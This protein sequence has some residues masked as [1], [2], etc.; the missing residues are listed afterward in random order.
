MDLLLRGK[1]VL[2]TGGSRGIGLAIA[3]VF[4]EEGAR[5]VICS[6]SPRHL[7]AAAKQIGEIIAVPCDVT[8]PREVRALLK[9][10][11]PLDVLVNNA[12]GMEHYGG[13]EGTTAGTW[14]RTMEANLISAVE[15]IR[16]ARAGLAERRGCVVNIAS[17]AARQPLRL[18]PDY[19]AAKAAL[20]S[21][22]KS[23]S[24]ELAADG[25]RVNA[26]CPG[27][28]LTDSWT[29]EARLLGGSKWKSFLKAAG[30]RAAGR[31]PLGRMGTPEEV[32]SVVAFL[33]SPRASW[34]TGAAFAVDGGAVKVI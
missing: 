24:N 26:V 29:E 31:V 33:A 9:R 16:A 7:V 20:L 30:D 34:V 10:S 5:V 19:S 11:G 17:E 23:L 25:I 8:K 4:H 2:V 6:R 21:A 12:G 18:G 32:A 3:R 22:T 13:F 15:M 14:R 1:T 28:V 27:P